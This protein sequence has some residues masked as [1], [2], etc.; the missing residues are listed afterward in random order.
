MTARVF[1]RCWLVLVVC[2]AFARGA[3]ESLWAGI[4]VEAPVIREGDRIKL[5]AR[6][7]LVNDGT[8]LIRPDLTK[9]H[10]VINGTTKIPLRDAPRARALLPGISM[11][12][13]ESIAR[14]MSKPGTYKLF[15]EGEGFRS[16]EITV[17]ILASP[18]T[19]INE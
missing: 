10:L 2:G 12:F 6:L 17:R 18:R 4:S 8:T 3:E 9:S 14:V 11:Q 19:P 1:L 16:D 13:G 15:W 5:W 7:A